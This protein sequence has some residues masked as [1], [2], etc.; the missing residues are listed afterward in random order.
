LR[1]GTEILNY[2]Q[3]SDLLR[4]YGYVIPDHRRY[5]VVELPWGF[6]RSALAEELSLDHKD[7]QE[8]ES[9]LDP[10]KLEESFIL[11]RDSG[12]PD[13]EGRHV[14]SAALREIPPEL[15]E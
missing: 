6:V 10:E 12:E 1:A 8:L 7:V 11:E 3:I 2:L 4:R 9:Q 13:S 14:H 15:D 5:D